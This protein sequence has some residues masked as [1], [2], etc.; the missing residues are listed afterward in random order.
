M[1]DSLTWDSGFTHLGFGIHSLW[2]RVSLTW[3]LLEIYYYIWTT[4]YLNYTFD[5]MVCGGMGAFVYDIY[6]L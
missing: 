1:G 3:D 6:L 2:F 4:L 5:V